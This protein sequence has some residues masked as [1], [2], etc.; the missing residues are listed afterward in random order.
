MSNPSYMKA[1]FK[2]NKNISE[3]K[4]VQLL[5]RIGSAE[6]CYKS[7]S[8]FLLGHDQIKLILVF[9]IC[10]YVSISFSSQTLNMQ[11]K[12]QNSVP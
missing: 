7:W 6:I 3:V 10:F 9:C 5:L 1:P 11:N 12:T 4:V 8:T 2:K